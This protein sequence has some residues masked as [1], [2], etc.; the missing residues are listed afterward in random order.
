MPEGYRYVVLEQP[1]DAPSATPQKQTTRESVDLCTTPKAAQH[2]EVGI[3]DTPNRRSATRRNLNRNLNR[4]ARTTYAKEM[5]DS[6]AT[7]QPTTIKIPKE[8]SDLKATWHAAAKEVAYKLLDLRKEGWKEYTLFEKSTVHNEI[9]EK[10][11]FDPPI[12]PKRVDK[13]L[14]A[15]FRTSR[16][17]WKAHWK[18]YGDNQRHHNCPKD[19]WAKLITWWCTEACQEEAAEMASRRSRVEANS[20]MGRNSLLERMEGSVSANFLC[21][22]PKYLY[23]TICRQ[24]HDFLCAMDAARYRVVMWAWRLAVC[25]LVQTD[26]IRRNA[27]RHLKQNSSPIQEWGSLTLCARM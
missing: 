2:T 8:R 25:R 1:N 12:D 18:K 24:W 4:K 11:K 9:N 14:S 6:L 23:I 5:K 19:A 7:G 16:A 20:K 27:R 10:Y 3:P 17:V 22:F 13:Y 21:F 15:H 26:A